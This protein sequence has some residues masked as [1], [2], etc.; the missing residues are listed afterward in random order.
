M[1]RNE[2]L[3]DLAFLAKSHH[4]VALG[5]IGYLTALLSDEEMLQAV[6][7]ARSLADEF[8]TDIPI[9]ALLVERFNLEPR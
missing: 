5:I 4:L 3:R 8:V 1:T 2:A 9:R 6:D 7:F